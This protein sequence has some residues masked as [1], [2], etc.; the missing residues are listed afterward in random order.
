M[1][2]EVDGPKVE[3]MPEPNRKKEQE[4]GATKEI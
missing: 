1:S 2:I 3:G 4:E